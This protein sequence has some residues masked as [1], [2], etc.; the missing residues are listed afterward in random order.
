[1]R[2]AD[3][4]MGELTNSKLEMTFAG[5][6]QQPADNGRDQFPLVRLNA[7]P[8]PALTIS[9]TTQPEILSRA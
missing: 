8:H 1:M 7:L 5:L 3:C 6:E 2:I 4:E 9:E